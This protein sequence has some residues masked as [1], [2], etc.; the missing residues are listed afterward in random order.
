MLTQAGG[1]G[2]RE[3]RGGEQCE[4]LRIGVYGLEMRGDRVGWRGMGSTAGVAKV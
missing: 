3:R 4:G 2:R 1:G